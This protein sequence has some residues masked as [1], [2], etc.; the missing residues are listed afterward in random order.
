MV[1][2]KT[3]E[4]RGGIARFQIPESW[5]EEYEPKGGGTFYELGED[6]GTLRLNVLD[7]ERRAKDANLRPTAFEILARTRNPAEILSLS[8][9]ISV[10]RYVE[11]GEED[12]VHLLFYTWQIC[13]CVTAVHFRMINFI[14][15]I[16]DGQEKDPKMQ[17]ELQMLDNL[18]IDGEHPRIEGVSGDY[19]QK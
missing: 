5:V 16:V 12:K 9:F 14:Y 2:L 1:P 6:T 11:H 18:I 15:T 8:D 3:I 17:A 13:L 19:F 4:Y 7:F 10:A